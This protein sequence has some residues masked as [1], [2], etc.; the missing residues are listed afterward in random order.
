[1]PNRVVL[2]SEDSDF[3]EYFTSRLGLRK[4]DEL[5][6]YDFGAVFEK[7]RLFADSVLIINSEGVED[8]TIE[9]LISARNIPS[10]IFAYNENSDFKVKTY[11][12]G[13]LSFVTPFTS[14]EEFNTRI[15]SALNVASNLQKA[16]KYRQILVKNDLLMPN[17]DVFIGYTTLL[18]EELK[19]ISAVS[20][21][22]VLVAISPNE[23]NKFLIES[24]QLEE[25][26]LNNIRKTDI[27]MSFAANK[28]FA[29]LY[30]TD[31]NSAKKV[32]EKIKNSIPEK[33]YAGFSSVNSK[34]RQ[35]LV[36]DVLNKLHE[37]I[38]A[39]KN[40]LNTQL[41]INNNSNKNFKTFRQEFNKRIEQIVMPVFYQIQ[42]KFNSK[43][44]GMM[45]EQNC[46]EGFKRICIKSRHNLAALEITWPG[47]SKINIDISYDTKKNVQPKRISFE[48]DELEAGLLEDLLERF[49]IEF[50]KEI[51]DDD[52]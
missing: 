2:V 31:I 37:A 38:N 40:N 33:I 14:D 29:L 19:K 47:F 12:L 24:S 35:Q 10:I 48:P 23:Q 11:K 16:D 44:F 36:N 46:G 27:L 15:A 9:L 18:D 20:C 32:W 22:A 39:D 51:E 6:K 8:K 25:A 7:I 3:F 1:M 13:A 4:S 43:L 42:Q 45:I 34:S 26:I 28:Y 5:F 21:K 41:M 30:N 49:I 52:T 50:K 17:N